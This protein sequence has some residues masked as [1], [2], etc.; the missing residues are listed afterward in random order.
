LPYARGEEPDASALAA[1]ERLAERIR[2]P[3]RDL[4]RGEEADLR[5]HVADLGHG[6][7]EKRGR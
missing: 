7:R 1:A 4:S 5:A 3:H 2:T 6:S